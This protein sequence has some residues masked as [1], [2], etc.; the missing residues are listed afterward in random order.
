MKFYT[1][2]EKMFIKATSWELAAILEEERNYWL[3]GS[4]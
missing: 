2:V 1:S 4:N 3:C